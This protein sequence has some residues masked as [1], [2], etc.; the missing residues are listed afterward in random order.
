MRRMKN[1]RYVI[2]LDLNLLEINGA[3]LQIEPKSS[4]IA[5]ESLEWDGLKKGSIVH[6]ANLEDKIGMLLMD[7]ARKADLV[8]SVSHVYIAI[9]GAEFE[10]IDR[11]IQ[12]KLSQGVR[13]FTHEDEK[14]FIKQAMLLPSKKQMEAV[15]CQPINYT[16]DLEELTVEL[17]GHQAEQVFLRAS[18]VGVKHQLVS[19]LKA[20]VE[21]Y[22]FHSSAIYS[23][24][25]MSLLAGSREEWRNKSIVNI[26]IGIDKSSVYLTTANNE[27]VVKT[28][29]FGLKIILQF[30]DVNLGMGREAAMDMPQSLFSC[31]FEDDKKDWYQF[32][33]FENNKKINR[34][35][36]YEKIASAICSVNKTFFATLAEDFADHGWASVEIVLLSGLASKIKFLDK[37]YEYLS[38]CKS[39]Y[40]YPLIGVRKEF[41][42][43]RTVPNAPLFG[44]L[45]KAMTAEK[46]V[47]DAEQIL[48]MENVGSSLVSFKDK[49]KNT[50][51]KVIKNLT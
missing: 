21:K 15:D 34:S 31:S 50:Y 12:G 16:L 18:V 5:F 19:Q 32:E 1:A 14:S 17:A 10:S 20:M 47:E 25:H 27:R 33:V 24:V 30:L 49:I 26:E 8:S 44:L 42:D 48:T 3:L 7:L 9:S 43:R 11:N 46:T 23:G 37:Y 29:D 35:V 6:P 45:M 39:Y 4:L 51:D 40:C 13:S 38:H 41:D 36:R 28:Y 2:V 22:D